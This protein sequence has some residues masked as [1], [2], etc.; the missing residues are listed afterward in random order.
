MKLCSMMKKN[1]ID[2]DW[3]CEG[4]VDN[5]SIEMLRA[6]Q[7]S[8]CRFLLY[9][10]ESANQRILN[11]YNKN[12]T[13][14][15]SILAVNNARRANIPYIV[16]SF[17][18]GAPSETIHE[19]RNTLRFASKLNLDF[20]LVNVLGI[21]PGTDIW[22]DLVRKNILNEETYWETGVS[23][24]YLNPEAISASQFKSLIYE[25]LAKFFLDPKYILKQ[26]YRLAINSYKFRSVAKGAVQNLKNF[27]NMRGARSFTILGPVPLQN[28]S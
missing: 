22:N 7:Q 1:R 10:I 28:Y 17:I 11:Y 15:Q 18:I 13:P 21:A 26:I 9:G 25:N 19:I 20:P 6:M 5:A 2:I 24:A 14:A 3:I 4:R 23:M 12:I 8:N 27:K 16:G